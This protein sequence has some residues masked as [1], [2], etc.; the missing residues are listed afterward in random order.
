[1]AL[2]TALIWSGAQSVLRL[3]LGFLNIKVAAIYLGATGMALVGQLNNFL[4][5]L[6]GFV[7]N[8]LHTGVLKMT[9]EHPTDH[10]LNARVWSTAMKMALLFGG[11]V[12]LLI[13][14]LSV[15]LSR[16]LF[17]S[18]A[19]WPVFLLAGPVVILIPA[20]L[21]LTG[22]LNGQKRIRAMALSAILPTVAGAMI[23]VPLVYW[24]GLW[25]GLIATALY[26]VGSLLVVL[27]IFIRVRAAPG[28]AFSRP[29]DAGVARELLRY[30]PMLLVHSTAGPFALLAVRT[31]LI[32]HFGLHEAG[33]WQAVS[34]ISDMDTMV[35]TTALSFYLMPHLSS[36]LEPDPFSNEL[37][38]ATMQVS[39]IAVVTAS[40]IYLLRGLVVTLALTSEFAPVTHLL[41]YQLIG[42]GLM[43]ASFPIRMALVIKVRTRWY[44][45]LELIAP[46][47]RVAITVGLLN[48]ARL[49]A[50][51]IAYM[52]AYLLVDFLLLVALRDYLGRYVGQLKRRRTSS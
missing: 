24:F 44:I 3:A 20:G 31:I 21:V 5:L 11:V 29:W 22:I 17:G 6:H 36:I 50:A 27:A 46:L 26:S 45:A 9:A 38:K 25:G 10:E 18:S 14:A 41:G 43:M 52:I 37:V 19:Y 28:N 30:F 7:G 35:L 16:H 42:D 40:S 13:V 4:S 39:A 32:S 48:V 51:T 47:L 33:L 8:A 2:R 34:R 23:F 12:A 49:Q 15:P 1:M